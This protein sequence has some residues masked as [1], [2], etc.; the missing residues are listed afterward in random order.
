MKRKTIQSLNFTIILILVLIISIFLTLYLI[1]PIYD[2]EWLSSEFFTIFFFVITGIT[3][4]VGSS[5]VIYHL[6]QRQKIPTFI[7]RIKKIKK[8]IR[9]KYPISESILYP[10]R[11]EYIVNKLG[12]KWK[13]LGLSLESILGI[14]GIKGKKTSKEKEEY[15]RGGI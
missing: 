7:R 6:N 4:A 13:I 14:E 15:Q 2:G 3:I 9:R 10:M 8:A 11:M 1:N 12:N 5:L